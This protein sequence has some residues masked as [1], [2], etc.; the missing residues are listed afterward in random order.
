MWHRVVV[1]LLAVSLLMLGADFAFGQT[2]VFGPEEYIRKTG[3]PETIIKSFSI[4]NPDGE[5][6]LV[7]QNG[8]GKRGR[9]SSAVI[10]LNGV[11]VVGPNAFNQQVDLITKPITLAQQNELA[12]EVRS[13]PGTAIII[14]I[15]GSA[16]P[17]PSPINS[18]TADP[19]G[20]PVNTPTQV[21]FTAAVLIISN[22]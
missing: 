9:V 1:C 22:W 15:F 8:E 16:A 18:I 12:V 19:D 6:T 11:Q 14:T 21:T 20:F 10:E 5:F 4:Q 13:Q 2:P 3:A 17:P 7:V